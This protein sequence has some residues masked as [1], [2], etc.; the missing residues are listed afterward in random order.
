MGKIN[1][2]IRRQLASAKAGKRAKREAEI[3]ERFHITE[4]GG[5]IYLLCYGTAVAVVNEHS[6]AVEITRQIN[7]ARNAA[8]D[9]DRECLEQNE[10]ASKYEKQ[11]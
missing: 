6:N 1:D 8:L 9:Y 10:N 4:R 3:S 11:Q 5:K 7:S 2:F